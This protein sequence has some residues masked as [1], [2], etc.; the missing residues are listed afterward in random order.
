MNAILINRLDR[1]FQLTFGLSQMMS[2]ST[3]ESRIKDVPSNSMG[4]QFWCIVGAR[5]SYTRGIAAGGWQ[6]F[7]C[8]LTP[9]QSKDPASIQASLRQT[10]DDAIAAVTNQELSDAQWQLVMDL[11]EHEVQHQGQLIRYFYASAI[12]FPTDFA[13]RYN[14]AQLNVDG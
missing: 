8:S 6:G 2:A 12:A 14:L 7:S 5:Q 4:S 11:W 3:L 13:N 10:H 1:A 9:T